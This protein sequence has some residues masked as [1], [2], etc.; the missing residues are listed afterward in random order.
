MS[1][2]NIKGEELGAVVALK[3]EQGNIIGWKF[4]PGEDAEWREAKGY[5]YD[6]NPV[7]PPPPPPQPE[8][9]PQPPQ[10]VF[11]K[12]KIRRA[13]R[14]LGLECQLNAIL[15]SDAT[16][17]ADWG[18]AQEIDLADPVLI[19]ALAAA[20]I[21]EAEIELVR[22]TIENGGVPPT[23]PPEPT[24]EPSEDSEAPEGEE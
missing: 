7:P 20:E 8:P 1:W 15:T 18:D 11:T 13:M 14:A 23:P 22:K 3:D 9:E 16:F 2:Y 10:T 6:H 21:T 12:L 24:P 17:A 5:I 4:N 19:A